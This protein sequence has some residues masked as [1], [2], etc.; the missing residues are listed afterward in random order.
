MIK[1]LLGILALSVFVSGCETFNDSYN[2]DDH[3]L[4]RRQTE[5]VRPQDQQLAQLSANLAALNANNA[6]IVRQINEINQ[7][8]VALQQGN[9]TLQNGINANKQELDAVKKSWQISS[10]KMIEQISTEMNNA[11][12]TNPPGATNKK[13]GPIGNGD[14]Y[15]HTVEAGSTLNAI[16]KKYSVSVTDIKTANAMNNDIIRVGQKLY[17]PKK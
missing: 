6:E 16:A 12:K 10:D 4:S 17:V 15:V 1:N 13:D 2:K 9:N 14:F 7:K 11:L 3:Y 5:T 8:I